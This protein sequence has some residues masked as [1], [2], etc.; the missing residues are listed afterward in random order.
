MQEGDV[1]RAKAAAIQRAEMAYHVDA[2]LHFHVDAAMSILGLGH[3]RKVALTI[4][5]AL[6][7]YAKYREDALIARYAC[8]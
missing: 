7:E 6:L 3:D 2:A 8:P 1:E 4:A 5:H